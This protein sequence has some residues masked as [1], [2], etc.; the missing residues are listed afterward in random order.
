MVV[1]S[2]QGIEEALW[3]F[4]SFEGE[5]CLIYDRISCPKHLVGPLVRLLA[6]QR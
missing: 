3:N 2:I 5:C 4:S 6:L 1:P